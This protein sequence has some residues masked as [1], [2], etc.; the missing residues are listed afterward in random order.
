M[1]KLKASIW[2]AAVIALTYYAVLGDRQWPWNILKFVSCLSAITYV[3]ALVQ[4]KNDSMKKLL[5]TY[6]DG[7]HLPRWADT[8]CYWAIV[9]PLAAQEHFVLASCWVLTAGIDLYLRD[10][11]MQEQEAGKRTDKEG[12][13]TLTI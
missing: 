2:F 1:K 10:I 6:R 3:S 4:R 9:L 7:R 11:A 8:V 12:H 5:Q 13:T